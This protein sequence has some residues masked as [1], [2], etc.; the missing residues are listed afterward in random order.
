MKKYSKALNRVSGPTPPPR[1]ASVTEAI[2]GPIQN[3]NT[4]G[5]Q[6]IIT[7]SNF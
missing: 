2:A 4:R 1:R 5:P 3:E 6:K 7:R